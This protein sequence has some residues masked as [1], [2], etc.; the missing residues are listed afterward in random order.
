MIIT[1][2]LPQRPSRFGNGPSGFRQ[3][4]FGRSG[5]SLWSNI[6]TTQTGTVPNVFSQVAQ[7]ILNILLILDHVN[8]KFNIFHSFLQSSFTWIEMDFL[9]CNFAWNFHHFHMNGYYDSG[10]ILWFYWEIGLHM[11]ID[12]LL[13]YMYFKIISISFSFFFFFLQ[14]M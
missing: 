10:Q 11:K 12:H 4:G 13:C 8:F 2:L 5:N 14:F 6:L 9:R 7:K 3:S 1:G